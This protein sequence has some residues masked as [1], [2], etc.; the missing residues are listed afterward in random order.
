MGGGGVG[1]VWCWAIGGRWWVLGA[2]CIAVLLACCVVML[3]CSHR[4]CIVA[5]ACGVRQA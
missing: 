5:P 4:A 3:P 2:V 1:A